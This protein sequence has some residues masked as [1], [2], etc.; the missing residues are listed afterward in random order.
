MKPVFKVTAVG[1]F[2]LVVEIIITVIVVLVMLSLVGV[3]P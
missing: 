2:A 3:I 1:V